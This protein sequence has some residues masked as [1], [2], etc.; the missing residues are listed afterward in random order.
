MPASQICCAE[1][2]TELASSLSNRPDVA[3]CFCLAAI[4]LSFLTILGSPAVGAAA[5]MQRLG[6]TVGSKARGRTLI[7]L[8]RR[9]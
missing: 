8:G 2:F 1:S 7:A 4:A 5:K 6:A 3:L 9:V